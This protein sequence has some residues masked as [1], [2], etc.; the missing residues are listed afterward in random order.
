MVFGESSPE[1]MPMHLF[2]G[3]IR[4]DYSSALKANVALQDYTVCPRH[5]YVDAVFVCNACKREFSWSAMEQRTWFE[6]YRFYVDSR[7]TRCQ[8]CRRQRRQKDHLQKEYNKL[9]ASARTGTGS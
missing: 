2:W 3:A 1:T 8:E 4:L 7:P 5:W 9:V 6:E